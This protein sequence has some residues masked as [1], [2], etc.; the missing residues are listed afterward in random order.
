MKKHTPG[1]WRICGGGRHDWI[2]IDA[3]AVKPDGDPDS[4]HGGETLFDTN[5]L[6]CLNPE[7][8]RR[9]IADYRLAA[10]A[11][12]LLEAAEDVLKQ[13]R[14]SVVPIGP[15]LS[16]S[17]RVFLAAAVRKAKGERTGPPMPWERA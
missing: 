1:P 2:R 6:N 4:E 11:P 3:G 14:E 8:K 7:A 12:E 9:V 16:D 15:D 5:E 10:S 17:I 13:Y